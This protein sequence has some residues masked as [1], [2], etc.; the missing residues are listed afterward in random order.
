MTLKTFWWIVAV[1][2]LIGFLPA[3]VIVSV[4]SPLM[5]MLSVIVMGMHCLGTIFMG[6]Y[7]KSADYID[8]N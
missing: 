5:S 8:E 3:L 6:L 2:F 1:Y 4:S 7:L